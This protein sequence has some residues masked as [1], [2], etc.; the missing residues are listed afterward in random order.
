MGLSPRRANVLQSTWVLNKNRHPYGH[1]NKHKVTFC[2]RGNQ[3]VDEV[4]VFET[5]ALVVSWIEVLI[6]FVLSQVLALLMQQ[7]D[8]TNEFCQETFDQNVFVE[9]SKGFEAPNKVLCL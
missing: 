9:L 8:C 1:L 2:V 5:Y 3:Q 4:D 6:R 7:A